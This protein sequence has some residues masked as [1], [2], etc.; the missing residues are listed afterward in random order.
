MTCLLK[1]QARVQLQHSSDKSVYVVLPI[2]HIATLIEMSLHVRKAARGCVQLEWPQE[3]VRFLEVLP[4]SVNLVYQILD[5]NDVVLPQVLL[6]DCVRG[7]GDSLL[8]HTSIAAFV[9][10]IPN[11]RDGRDAVRDVWS[12]KFQH[13]FGRGVQPH[14]HAVVDLH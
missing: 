9:Q 3:V 14:E 2:A 8:P 13:P 11:R 10:E 1:K 12:H 6:D 5:A 4:K 7:Q